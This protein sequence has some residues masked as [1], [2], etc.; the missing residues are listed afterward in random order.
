MKYRKKP[1]VIE[2]FQY[3]GDFKNQNEEYYVPQWAVEA[4]E[5]GTLFFDGPTLKVK[6][7]EGDMIANV[8]DYIIR[9]VKGELYPCKS[10]IF[11]VTYEKVEENQ[12]LEITL[13]VDGKEL[14]KCVVD[15]ISKLPKESLNENKFAIQQ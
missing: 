1:V 13:A 14:G 11:E 9:G 12:K 10:E 6:T 4:Y 7:L 2:A 3:D 8:N 15:A 5:N